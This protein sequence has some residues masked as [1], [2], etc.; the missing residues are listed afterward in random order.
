MPKTLIAVFASS[1]LG[2][3]AQQDLLNHQ[4][5]EAS[6]PPTSVVAASSFFSAC[7]AFCAALPPAIGFASDVAT[8]L[9]IV[10]AF[11]ASAIVVSAT[12]ILRRGRAVQPIKGAEA[13]AAKAIDPSQGHASCTA[14]DVMHI[15]MAPWRRLRYH[16]VRR[17]VYAQKAAAKLEGFLPS[18]LGPV[19]PL[20]SKLRKSCR[21]GSHGIHD[22]HEAS[23][24]GFLTPVE[25]AA[26]RSAPEVAR[27]VHRLVAD[28][29]WVLEEPPEMLFTI[30]EDEDTY[31][32]CGESS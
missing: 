20:T 19:D 17:R 10:G 3:W 1:W 25:V 27:R 26:C 31:E 18:L 21:Q 32:D 12:V 16:M 4:A 13:A 23:P 15:L 28:R 14:R 6:A 24:V 8:Q 29:W 9:F 30:F 5:S 2:S 7:L 22:W 11:V